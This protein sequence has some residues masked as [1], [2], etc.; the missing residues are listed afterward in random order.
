MAS[1][2][3]Q[4]T[5]VSDTPGKHLFTSTNQAGNPGNRGKHRHAA[6]LAQAAKVKAL[7]DEMVLDPLLPFTEARLLL[8][9]SG[10]TLRALVK[11]G[12]LP[13]WR[14]SAKGHM[15]FRLSTLVKFRESG[16]QIGGK[17]G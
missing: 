2:A 15:R 4:P 12:K 5:A 14:A 17:N 10:N 1:A 9:V 6:L 3:N 16:F 8:G 7:K 11:R 13:V